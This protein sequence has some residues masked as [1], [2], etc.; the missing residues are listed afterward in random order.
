MSA[1]RARTDLRLVAID[2]DGTLINNAK[3]IMAFTRDE[4]ARVAE[5]GAI[6]SIVTARSIAASRIIEHKL[7]TATSHIAFG[8]ALVRARSTDE[9]E[10]ILDRPFTSAAVG[11]MLDI[12]AGRPV[13][14]GV[15]TESEWHVSDIG[16]WGLREARNTSIWP[17]RIG[18]DVAARAPE[19]PVYKVMFR[20][21][22]EHLAPIKAGIDASL[23]E[24]FAHFAGRVLEITTTRK[25]VAL[26]ALAEHLKVPLDAC[27]AFGDT[28]ADIPMLEQVGVG[29]LMG[30]ADPALSVAEHVVRTLSND[31]DGVGLSL[32]AHF[33]TDA[34]FEI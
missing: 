31:E 10:T 4:V 14:V 11:T 3:Q 30:N 12:A 23:P 17:N 32:R 24:V 28:E 22:P 25:H 18:P 26:A 27:I 33:P 13:H 9:F 16:I 34:P 8:G 1:E 29:V 20:G 5:A 15:Y 19:Q 21:E 2:I 6:V 7:G